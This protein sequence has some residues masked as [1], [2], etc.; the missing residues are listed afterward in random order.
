MECGA[1][2]DVSEFVLAWNGAI[3]VRDPR[4]THFRLLQYKLC[5]HGFDTIPSRKRI[6]TYSSVRVQGYRKGHVSTCHGI[7]LRNYAVYIYTRHDSHHNF[8]M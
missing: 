3:R 5:T 7:T 8:I 2:A 6:C 4:S 1:R